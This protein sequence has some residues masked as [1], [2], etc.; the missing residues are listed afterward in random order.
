[1]WHDSCSSSKE[2][3]IPKSKEVKKMRRFFIV[4]FTLMAVLAFVQP[5]N[6]LTMQFFGEDEGLGDHN[7]K[8]LSHPNSDQ[9]RNDFFSFLVGVGTEDFEGFAFHTASPLA[10]DFGA[11]GTAT[12]TGNGE[13]VDDNFNPLNN[14]PEPDNEHYGRFAISGKNYFG[15]VAAPGF[16]VA[17][18]QP[19]AAFGFYATDIGDFQ[20]T[21]TLT[22]QNGETETINYPNTITTG[23]T[24]SYF[25]YI[26]TDALFTSVA[27]S[28][29]AGGDAFGFDDLT[30]GSVEQVQVPE[31]AT[32]LLLGSGLIGLVGFKRR[33]RN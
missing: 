31:P 13:V 4:V 23:G 27:F 10:L 33:F 18:S 16:S 7:G 24:V 25:G 20:G 1:M 8:L 14:N 12:L 21:L 15:Q 19:V 3:V 9:A 28:T 29:T 17:L 6:S 11:A 2:N 32:L 30:I 26:N 22:F 5:A